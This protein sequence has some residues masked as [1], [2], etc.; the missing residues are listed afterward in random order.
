MISVDFNYIFIQYVGYLNG[1]FN[2]V[3]PSYAYNL[4]LTVKTLSTIPHTI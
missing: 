4:N 2:I 1:Y 3:S